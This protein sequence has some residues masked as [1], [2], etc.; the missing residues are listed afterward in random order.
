M[1][2]CCSWPSFW[3]LFSCLWELGFSLS[4]K[5]G[6]VW[7]VVFGCEVV[8][9]VWGWVV[10]GWFWC[11]SVLIVLGAQLGPFADDDAAPQS[12]R[13]AQPDPPPPC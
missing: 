8:V 10:W 13:L 5:D 6:M 9:V 12:S 7:W 1:V 4:M 3:C 11:D 2:N